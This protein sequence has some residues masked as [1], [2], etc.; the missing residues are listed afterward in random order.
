MPQTGWGRHFTLL[1]S[2]LRNQAARKKERKI[3]KKKKIQAATQKPSLYQMNGITYQVPHV[4]RILNNQSNV[5]EVS[6]FHGV[7][8]LIN[9]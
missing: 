1:I 8:P 4:M 9:I 5:V 7:L 2:V 6:R 3:K